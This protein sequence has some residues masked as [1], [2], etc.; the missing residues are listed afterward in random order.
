MCT[1]EDGALYHIRERVRE[2]A[3]SISPN[4]ADLHVP[5]HQRALA[6]RHLNKFGRIEWSS[7]W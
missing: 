7:L 1:G 6:I 2:G 5:E 4:A 3:G